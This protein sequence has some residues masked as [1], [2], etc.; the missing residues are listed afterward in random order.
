MW[1]AELPI[2][3]HTSAGGSSG[4]THP[5]ADYQYIYVVVLVV[6]ALTG[7]ARTWGL[8]RLWGGAS[9][10]SSASMVALSSAR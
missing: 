10:Y 4:S 9:G 8:G 3:Q 7:A 1:L 5:F 6:L 2:A